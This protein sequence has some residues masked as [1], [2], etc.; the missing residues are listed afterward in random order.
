MRGSIGSIGGGCCD[1]V[2][3]FFD[4]DEEICGKKINK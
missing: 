3:I 1:D 2:G 4:D